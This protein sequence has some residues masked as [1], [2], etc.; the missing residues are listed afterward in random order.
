MFLFV[1]SL[2]FLQLI[3]HVVPPLYIVQALQW[4]DSLT[5]HFYETRLQIL[6]ILCKK[7]QR[8]RISTQSD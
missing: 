1:K 5:Y 3:S 4:V 8:F 6:R 7:G 2:P